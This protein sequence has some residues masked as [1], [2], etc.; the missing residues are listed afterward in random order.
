MEKTFPT[1]VTTLISHDIDKNIQLGTSSWQKITHCNS[2]SR[3]EIDLSMPQ[4]DLK[5]G[6]GRNK[7]IHKLQK[8]KYICC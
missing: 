4:G 2:R 5:R 3:K 1:N 6:K 7:L 8:K